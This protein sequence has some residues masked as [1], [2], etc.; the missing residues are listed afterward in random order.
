MSRAHFLYILTALLMLTKLVVGIDGLPVRSVPRTSF[1]SNRFI[2]TYQQDE[3]DLTIISA[4]CISFAV[5]CGTPVLLLTCGT[6]TIACS[7]VLLLLG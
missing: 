7:Y 6:H 2:V 1:T 5:I 3:I 4:W